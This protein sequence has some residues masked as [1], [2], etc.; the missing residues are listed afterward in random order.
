VFAILEWLA[1]QLSPLALKPAG[2][3]YGVWFWVVAMAGIHPGDPP[4]AFDPFGVR[5]DSR[6][7]A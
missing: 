6:S 2:S 7:P 1:A 4:R 3:G 5:S